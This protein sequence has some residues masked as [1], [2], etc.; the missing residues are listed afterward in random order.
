MQQG[1]WM[2]RTYEAGE[3]A[4]KIKWLEPGEKPSRAERRKAAA[5]RKQ[6]WNEHNAVRRLARAIHANFR[7]GR[8]VLLG[9]DYDE[10]HLPEDR[11]G[12]NRQLRLWLERVRRA[13]RRA[14]VPLRYIA[15]SSDMDGKTG[16]LV[17]W[18][19]HVLINRE[20]AEL[21]AGKWTAGGTQRERL[22]R[23]KDQTSLA[24][25]LLDQVRREVPEEKKYIPSR[26]LVRVVPKDR[27][28]LS[29]AELKPPKGALLLQR[30]EYVPGQP[31]YIRY[32]R[33]GAWETK[34]DEREVRQEDGPARE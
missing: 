30:G 19:H 8:D 20:A 15:V 1:H 5:E 26:S 14:D 32:V 6:K 25:Y 27:I 9:L 17:R 11:A 23:Q 31:Q 21:A 33:P 2:I 29:G 16:E 3:I 18:H 24:A 34:E 22:T 28:A 13:C 12:A 4:E 7:G 10:T